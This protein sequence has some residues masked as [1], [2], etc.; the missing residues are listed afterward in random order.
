MSCIKTTVSIYYNKLQKKSSRIHLYEK[1]FLEERYMQ[2]FFKVT[3]L[4]HCILF[5]PNGRK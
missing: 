4:V 1:E 2:S 3:M 5:A